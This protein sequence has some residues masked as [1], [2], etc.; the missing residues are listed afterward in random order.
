M[1]S[2]FDSDRTLVPESDV[3]DL[4]IKCSP[5]TQRNKQ[6]SNDEESNLKILK[7]IRKVENEIDRDIRELA[8]KEVLLKRAVKVLETYSKEVK[9]LE[10]IEK[11]RAICQ[12]GMSYLHNSILMKIDRM[13]GYQEYRKKEMDAAKRQLEYYYDDGIQQQMEDILESPD[14]FHLPEE[15]KNEIRD[16]I[17]EKVKEAEEE[18]Q[19]QL[20]KIESNFQAHD[21]NEMTLEELASKIKVDFSMVYPTQ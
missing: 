11:W 5:Q 4:N 13:G 12:C 21:A 2:E 17:D 18:K 6:L 19:K 7:E 10:L 3:S 16:R 14:F 9:T 1:N 20:K 15:E 8:K